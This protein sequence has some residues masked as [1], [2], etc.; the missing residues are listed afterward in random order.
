MKT[1]KLDHIFQLIVTDLHEKVDEAHTFAEQNRE[2]V[3]KELEL[4]LGKRNTFSSLQ[5]RYFQREFT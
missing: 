2:D 5:I 1:E 4:L 3:N